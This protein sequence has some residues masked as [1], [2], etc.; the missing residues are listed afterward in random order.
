[1]PQSSFLRF[2]KVDSE[3]QRKKLSACLHTYTL[4]RIDYRLVPFSLKPFCR[5]DLGFQTVAF[6]EH[7]LSYILDF[8]LLSWIWDFKLLRVYHYLFV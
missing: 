6:G 4:V 8:K 1:M 3:K 7:E 5:L 2:R